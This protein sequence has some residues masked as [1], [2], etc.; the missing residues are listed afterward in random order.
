MLLNL[1]QV[2]WTQ[3]RT[4]GLSRSPLMTTEGRKRVLKNKHYHETKDFCHVSD[5]VDLYFIHKIVHF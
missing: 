1:A 4:Q 3:P 5:L 2:I